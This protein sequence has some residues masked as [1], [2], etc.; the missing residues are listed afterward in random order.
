MSPINEKAIKNAT[1][2]LEME[3]FVVLPEYKKLCEKLLDKEIT[4]AEYISA[5][6]SMQGINA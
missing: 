4:M 1:A 5:V 2:S 3:G 6:K